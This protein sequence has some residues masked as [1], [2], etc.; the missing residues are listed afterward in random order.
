ML[1]RVL[2]GAVMGLAGVCLA[3]NA[4]A[5]VANFNDIDLGTQPYGH[6]TNNF[7]DGGLH[8]ADYGFTIGTAS[9]DLPLFT[10]SQFME[11][12]SSEAEPLTI[13]LAAGGAFNMTSFYM[14]LGDWNVGDTDLNTGLLNGGTDSV[15]L[16]GQKAA[17][18]LSQCTLTAT[19]EVGANWTIYG[20]GGFTDLASLTIYQ[21]MTHGIQTNCDAYPPTGAPGASSQDCGWLAFDNFNYVVDTDGFGGGPNEPPGSVSSTP[22][23]IPEPASWALMIA[24]FGVVG[25]ALR[26]RRTGLAAA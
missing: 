17:G 15:M 26:R 14:G 18:C 2:C 25:A 12:G 21:P 1:K 7:S 20:L 9:F 22:A 4:H 23:P 19:V 6:Y 5:A 11:V 13:S 10:T 24:G 8:F 3:A 16:V